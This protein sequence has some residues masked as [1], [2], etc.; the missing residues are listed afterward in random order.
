MCIGCSFLIWPRHTDLQLI[1]EVTCPIVTV[2]SSWNLTV[3]GGMADIW[4]AEHSLWN[5]RPTDQKAALKLQMTPSLPSRWN[6]WKGLKVNPT[7][8][9]WSKPNV[10]KATFSLSR[11]SRLNIHSG[12]ASTVLSRGEK[13]G[14]AARSAPVSKHISTE[15]AFPSPLW[16]SMVQDK[17]ETLKSLL[18]TGNP[19]I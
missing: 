3:W 16:D 18:S 8:N 17:G 15:E 5:K 7:V 11:G 12:R 4:A 1:L 10:P 14:V 2:W 9:V 19:F 13:A 6:T